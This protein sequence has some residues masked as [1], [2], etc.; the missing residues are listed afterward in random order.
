VS[1]EKKTVGGGIRHP[2]YQFA[3]MEWR[4]GPTLLRA[5]PLALSEGTTVPPGTATGKAG[6][7][8]T[9]PAFV[10]TAP[11]RRRAE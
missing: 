2:S 10:F 9:S 5:G 11:E 8:W 6:E 4:T 3:A 7:L 1:G